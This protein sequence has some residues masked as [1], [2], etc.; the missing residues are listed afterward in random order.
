MAGFE[1]ATVLVESIQEFGAF[2]SATLNSGQVGDDRSLLALKVNDADLSLDHGFPARVIVPAL[3]G[4]HNT[5]WVRKM[6]FTEA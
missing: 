5:K 3:P 2:K 1:S 6:T 4:V